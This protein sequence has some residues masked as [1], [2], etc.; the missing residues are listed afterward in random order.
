M[1][2]IGYS[3]NPHK[4]M[5]ALK[6]SNPLE[7]VMLLVI[8]GKETD[9]KTLHKRFEDH[10]HHGEWF[11]YSDEI[12][13]YVQSM[14]NTQHD[15]RYEFGL[16][17]DHDIYGELARIRNNMNLPLRVVGEKMGI[18]PQSVK[19]IEMRER[20]GTI[21]INNMRRYAKSLG[22]V[23]IYKLKYAPEEAEEVEV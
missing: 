4:R 2:K 17:G 8:E 19:E 11:M 12:R 10:K 7:L 23:L 21:T 9:E 22:Y 5:A 16:L 3:T 20:A 13:E 1:V 18:T 6:T 14:Q 15:L